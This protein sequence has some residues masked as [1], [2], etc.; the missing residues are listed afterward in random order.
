MVCRW[1]ISFFESP[2]NKRTRNEGDK[3]AGG[4]SLCDVFLADKGGSTSQCFQYF[5]AT[6][7]A[8]AARG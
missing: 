8:L 6:A 5:S 7:L 1:L 3:C 4:P 2:P